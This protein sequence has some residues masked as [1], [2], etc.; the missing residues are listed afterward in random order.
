MQT[1]RHVTSLPAGPGDMQHHVS[2]EAAVDADRR[3]IDP[4]IADDTMPSVDDKHNPGDVPGREHRV[5]P[6]HSRAL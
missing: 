1:P 3:R 5:T 2:L 4:G 6:P